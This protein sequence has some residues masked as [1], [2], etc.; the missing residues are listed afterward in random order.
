MSI[1][2]TVEAT[3]RLLGGHLLPVKRLAGDPE[4]KTGRRREPLEPLRSAYSPDLQ[5]Q[6]FVVVLQ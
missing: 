1:R 4:R 6:E 2:P 3:P 5:A